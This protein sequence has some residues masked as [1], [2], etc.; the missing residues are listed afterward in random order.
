MNYFLD[1][2]VISSVLIFFI[3]NSQVLKSLNDYYSITSIS[4][5]V[6]KLSCFS[7]VQPFAIPWTVAYQLLYPRD[8]LGK[9]SGVGCHFLLQGIFLTQWSNLHLLHWQVD[10]SW[11]LYYCS[12]LVFCDNLGGG[13]VWEVGERFKR[14]AHMC[15]YGWFMLIYGRNQHNIIQ[16]LSS[17]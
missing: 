8:S 10:S 4:N 3:F 1:K 5:S 16:Q 7:S 13:V 14:G 9:N 11:A 12:N 6:C 15:T 2:I 17:N